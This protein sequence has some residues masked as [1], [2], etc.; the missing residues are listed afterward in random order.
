MSCAKTE[1]AA[2]TPAEA[3]CDDVSKQAYQHPRLLAEDQD[4]VVR[5]LPKPQV[6]RQHLRGS[7]FQ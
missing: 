2:F 7:L 5:C 1:A 6:I 4:L 3:H